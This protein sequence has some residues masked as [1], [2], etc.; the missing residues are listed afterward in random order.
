MLGVIDL[1]LSV[2]P[3]AGAARD[4][5]L[6]AARD[7]HPS[8]TVLVADITG[9]EDPAVSPTEREVEAALGT[10]FAGFD[11]IAA[12]N[13]LRSTWTPGDPYVATAG[14]GRSGLDHADRATVT[15]LQL[16]PCLAAFARRT[17]TRLH[18]RV[19]ISSGAVMAGSVGDRRFIYDLWGETLQVA[20][21]LER[22]GVADRVLV[23]ES[24][25]CLL[26]PR[27][28]LERRNAPANVRIDPAAAWF[29]TPYRASLDADRCIVG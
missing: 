25:R 7:H 2:L 3:G 28:Q 11:R 1:M 24:T 27:F 17:G 26:G 18:A 21:R 23:S 5:T 4:P 14:L 12:A 15:G 8:V 19:G 16:I 22:E 29:V 6:G 20:S 10:I 13:G 9:F